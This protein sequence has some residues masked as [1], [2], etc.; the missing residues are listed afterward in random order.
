MNNQAVTSSNLSQKATVSSV[1]CKSGADQ[2]D[3][4]MLYRKPGLCITV[5]TSAGK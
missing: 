3:M 2:A 1:L 4:L 5:P